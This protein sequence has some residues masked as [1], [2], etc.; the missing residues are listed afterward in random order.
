ML[1]RRYDN[2]VGSGTNIDPMSIDESVCKSGVEAGI[3]FLH[4]TDCVLV[5]S[6]IP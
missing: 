4:G 3:C 1:L 6:L 5:L 2:V